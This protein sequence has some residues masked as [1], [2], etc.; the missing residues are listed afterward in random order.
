MISSRVGK[1]FTPP[2]HLER[3]RRW[4][5]S[6]AKTNVCPSVDLVLTG[7][8]CNS[9][10]SSLLQEEGKEEGKIQNLFSLTVGLLWM[11][12]AVRELD[13]LSISEYTV[14]YN[15]H[16]N[17]LSAVKYMKAVTYRQEL[18]CLINSAEFYSFMNERVMIIIHEHDFQWPWIYRVPCFNNTRS[19]L[20]WTRFLVNIDQ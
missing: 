5:W 3:Y 19:P 4:H 18:Q 8:R 1:S 15:I 16:I 12:T 9:M 20:K 10:M 6:R 11:H 17:A 14:Q 7:L 2:K 13:L